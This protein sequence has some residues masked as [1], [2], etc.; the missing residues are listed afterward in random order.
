MN[1]PSRHTLAAILAGKTSGDIDMN[2]SI[3][4][5]LRL[6][7]DFNG[8]HTAAVDRQRLICIWTELSLR[9]VTGKLRLLLE[10]A[11]STLRNPCVL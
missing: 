7:C 1:L 2:K 10:T 3:L 8:F 9:K 4:D 11:Y 5:T 6:T